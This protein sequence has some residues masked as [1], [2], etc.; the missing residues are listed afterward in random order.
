MHNLSIPI[1][2]YCLKAKI[3]EKCP[4]QEVVM[5]ILANSLTSKYTKYFTVG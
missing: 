3:K 5:A 1:S 4:Q 2:H